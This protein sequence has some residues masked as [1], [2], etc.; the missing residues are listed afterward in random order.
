MLRVDPSPAAELGGGNEEVE[1]GM[2]RRRRS[3]LLPDKYSPGQEGE[4]RG[5]QSL[6]VLG[7]GGQLPGWADDGGRLSCSGYNMD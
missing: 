2:K 6:Q 1:E 5:S 3:R 4:E 7:R